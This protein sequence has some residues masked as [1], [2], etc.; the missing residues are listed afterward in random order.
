MSRLKQWLWMIIVVAAMLAAGMVSGQ[1]FPNKPIRIVTA[2]TGGT[3]DLVARLIGQGFSAAFSQQVVVDN[4]GGS[5]IIPVQA[6]AKAPPDGYTLLLLSN[7]VWTLPFLQNVPYDPVRDLAPITL[8]ASSPLILVVH[9]SLPVSTV[10]TLITLGKARPG[11]LNYATGPTGT[12]NHLAGELFR[13]MTGVNIVRVS[14][15][16]TGTAFSDLLAGQVQLMFANVAPVTPHVKSGRLRALAV[17][18]PAPS[19]LFP[20]LPTMAA[21]GVP[22][23]ES[24]AILGVFAPA[25]TPEGVIGRLNQ[26]IVR[27]LTRADVKE[28]LFNASVETVAS[29]PEQLAATIKADM[30]RM[31]KVIKEAGIRQE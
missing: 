7:G 4:R 23:Y 10:K 25:G 9:P 6:V 8:A 5:F 28:R 22:G 21:A 15:K 30:V 20:G 12:S 17:T 18:S 3:A 13:S 14:Y 27:T 2:G 31:G 16:G 1:D 26:E 29:A 11:E 24:E 19:V